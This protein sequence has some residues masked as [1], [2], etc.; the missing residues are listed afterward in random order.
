MTSV[1]TQSV[2]FTTNSYEYEVVLH[3]VIKTEDSE[4][5][6]IL[7]MIK[8]SVLGL[9]GCLDPPTE[10]ETF[11]GGVVGVGLENI[12]LWPRHGRPSQQ[13]LY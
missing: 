7:R 2:H 1:L 4:A 3:T 9:N 8:H 11:S 12:Q 13:L 6:F 10:R 5:Q